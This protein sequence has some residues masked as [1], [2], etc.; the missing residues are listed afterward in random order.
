MGSGATLA[1]RDPSDPLDD[2]PLLRS[3]ADPVAGGRWGSAS[4]KKANWNW[5]SPSSKTLSPRIRRAVE[6]FFTT[7][8][9]GFVAKFNAVVESLAGEENSVLILRN[10]TLQRQ[11]ETNDERIE[12]FN[13]RLD[14]ERER[15]LTYYYNLELAISKIK[16]NMSVVEGL[17]N[18]AAVTR[19]TKA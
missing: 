17:A 19:T 2:Q 1:D 9:M 16:A 15:L 18:A 4:T 13:T 5:T 12:F 3:R 6:S 8:D 14:V 10:A 11:I 7:K